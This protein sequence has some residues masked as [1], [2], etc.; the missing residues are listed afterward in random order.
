M[1]ERIPEREREN[2]RERR[3]RERERMLAQ[4]IAFRENVKAK[5]HERQCEL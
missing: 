5:P 3:E 4:G 2:E 1:R